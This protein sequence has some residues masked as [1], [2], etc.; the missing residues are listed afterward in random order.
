MFSNTNSSKK[1]PTHKR[2][3]RYC[4]VIHRWAGLLIGVQIFIWFSSGL[5][6]SALPLHNVHGKHLHTRDELPQAHI[7]DYKISLNAVI[8]RYDLNPSTIKLYRVDSVPVYE[9]WDN[10]RILFSGITGKRLPLL[11]ARFIK[12]KAK[13]L[14]T[15]TQNIASYEKIHS[16]P[17]EVSNLKAPVWKVIFDDRLKT[18]F[19]FDPYNGKLLAVR[20]DLWRLFDFVWMLHIMDYD[21]RE[22]FNNPLLIAF[23]ACAVLFSVSGFILLFQIFRRKFFSRLKKS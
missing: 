14:F 18:T 22:N 20:S 7:Q 15:G 5:L 8:T 2:V 19:Y 6:M 16:L 3:Y 11:D 17:L 9:V 21:T 12:E 13:V 4:R 10:G 23:S 1:H